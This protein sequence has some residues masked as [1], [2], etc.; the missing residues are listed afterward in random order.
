MISTAAGRQDNTTS[1]ERKGRTIN[2]F[3]DSQ[4]WK[5]FVN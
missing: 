3:F 5:N 2:R 1:P 4:R